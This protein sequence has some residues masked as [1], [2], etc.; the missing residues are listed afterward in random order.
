MDD[1]EYPKR[2]IVG[3]GIVAL[4]GGHVLLVRRGKPPAVG[5]WTLPGGGQELGETAQAAARRELFEETGI[6]VGALVLAAQVDSIRHDAAGRV[7][8]HYTIIDFAARWEA[9]EPIAGSDVTEAVWAPLDQLDR[10]ELWS[11]A[12]RVIAIARSL[13]G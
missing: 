10:F 12:H 1:R 11:E 2:P 9:G 5:T 7:Q 13:V 4:K 3:I 8:Y 6:S